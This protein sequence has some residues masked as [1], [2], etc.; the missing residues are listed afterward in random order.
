LQSGFLLRAKKVLPRSQKKWRA[1]SAEKSEVGKSY[2]V[3][4]STNLL[5]WQTLESGIIGTGAL[6][7]RR[8][9]NLGNKVFV[10]VREE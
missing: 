6:E 1:G 4:L 10:R 8:V 5:S 9:P 7:S 3:E 2:R